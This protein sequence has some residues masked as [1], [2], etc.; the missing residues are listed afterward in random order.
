MRLAAVADQDLDQRRGDLR[1][2]R[3]VRLDARDEI[4]KGEI[5]DVGGICRK[6]D[7]LDIRQAGLESEIQH[8]RRGDGI[9]RHHHV[10]ERMAAADCRPVVAALRLLRPVEL[11]VERRKL[12]GKREL[13]LSVP[14]FVEHTEGRHVAHAG[15]PAEARHAGTGLPGLVLRQGD[16]RIVQLQEAEIGRVGLLVVFRALQRRAHRIGATVLLALDRDILAIGDLVG[17]VVGLPLRDRDAVGI[18]HFRREHLGL[19]NVGR[20]P[21]GG[22]RQIVPFRAFEHCHLSTAPVEDRRSDWIM[23]RVRSSPAG[24]C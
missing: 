7:H 18:A 4:G 22:A 16:R 13:D 21:V 11:P 1:V 17:L 23:L 14:Q 8:D 5:A 20:R 6:T 12:V 19:G 15:R 9:T 2:A 10:V 3:L 24:S